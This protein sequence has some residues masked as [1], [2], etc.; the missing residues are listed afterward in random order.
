MEIFNVDETDKLQYILN[1]SDKEFLTT[2]LIN[3][4]IKTAVNAIN[5]NKYKSG[6]NG[7]LVFF[8]EFKFSSNQLDRLEVEDK[9]LFSLFLNNE[10]YVNVLKTFFNVPT[11]AKYEF[12]FSIVQSKDEHLDLITTHI[13]NKIE[14]MIY[15]FHVIPLIG[16]FIKIFKINNNIKNAE[17]NYDNFDIVDLDYTNE[18]L[19][20]SSK[21]LFFGQNKN[22]NLSLR[23]SL[24]ISIM[25]I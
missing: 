16:D 14:D 10:K 6:I 4:D 8:K 19:F 15:G 17:T 1:N 22:V 9:N 24:L 7:P 2:N 18:F 25:K 11:D 23:K 20:K 21:K 13:K 5:I 3:E 12:V